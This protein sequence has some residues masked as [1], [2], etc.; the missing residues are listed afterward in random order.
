MSKVLI[1]GGGLGG[2]ATAAALHHVGVDAHV[3]ERSAALREI[4]AG[5]SVWPNATRVL[6]EFG[7][8]DEA[9][10]CSGEIRRLEV[11][12]PSGRLLS[13]VT[14][15]GREAQPSLCI[16]RADLLALLVSLVP[17]E[18]IHLGKQFE[19][20]DETADGVMARFSDGSA[21]AGDVLIGADGLFSTVRAALFGPRPPVYRGCHGW[22]GLA[23]ATFDLD[24]TAI[25]FWGAGRRF[26]I[27]PLGRQ[28]VFWYAT[29]NAPQ[30]SIGEPRTWKSRLDELF[31]GWDERVRS[32]IHVTPDDALLCHE[33]CD[34]PPH[35]RWGRRRV[36]LLGD[37][38]HPTTPFLGQGACMALEDAVVLARCIAR[39]GVSPSALRQYKCERL[40]RTTA[41]TWQSRQIGWLGQWQHPTMVALRDAIVRMT[42]S[43]FHEWPHR[44]LFRGV[45]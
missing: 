15:P 8:L 11:R 7:V 19:A 22:R 33:L 20:M 43:L 34:R 27:E 26:G 25:E 12:D 4:G 2:V 23:D 13:V 38:A 30:G 28:R 14:A 3:Y 36:T 1:V 24:A 44:L 16:H 21:V 40:V 29:E 39:R 37:A 35:G 10:S 6:D 32:T 18:R 45:T 42:P 31:A 5:L 41:V 9:R 17:P